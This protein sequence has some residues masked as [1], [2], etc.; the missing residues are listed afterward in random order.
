M[1]REVQKSCVKSRKLLPF[2][3]VFLHHKLGTCM[4]WKRFCPTKKGYKIPLLK[5]M[6]VVA[7]NQGA[8]L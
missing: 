7:N 2:K 1:S 4:T 8:F 6:V 3:H 5:K